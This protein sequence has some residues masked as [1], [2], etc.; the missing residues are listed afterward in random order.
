VAAAAQDMRGPEWQERP[1]VIFSS[2]T[3]GD[4]LL[5]A[6]GQDWQGPPVRLYCYTHV[7]L[8]TKEH[9]DRCMAVKLAAPN[10]QSVLDEIGADF[11][12]LE[13]DMYEQARHRAQ[14][15]AGGFSNLIDH[16][17][18]ASDRWQVISEPDAP[19]FVAQR[20]R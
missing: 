2:E 15:K 10:W 1:R 5:W 4:Y 18:A 9:W 19:V 17:R 3:E 14:G 13:D 7:H 6:L 12:V 8:F 20:V 11:V 16:V